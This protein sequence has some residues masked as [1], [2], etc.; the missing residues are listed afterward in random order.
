MKTALEVLKN[1]PVLIALL[2]LIIFVS[3]LIRKRHD[4]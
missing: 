2:I 1:L 4:D 3:G